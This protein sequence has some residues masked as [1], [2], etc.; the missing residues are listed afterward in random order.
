MPTSIQLFVNTIN[1]VSRLSIHSIPYSIMNI[2]F[3]SAHAI[4]GTSSH[5]DKR[6]IVKIANKAISNTCFVTED[7]KG[8]ITNLYI[9]QKK[10]FLTYVYA[11]FI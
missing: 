11:N 3:L 8:Y 6:N 7:K 9:S 10:F 5:R 1:T 4:C 2:I